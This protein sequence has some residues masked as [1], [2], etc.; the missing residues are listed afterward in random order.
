MNFQKISNGHYV[1]Q[2]KSHYCVSPSCSRQADDGSQ[3]CLIH[4]LQRAEAV[5]CE[6]CQ[7]PFE[8]TQWFPNIACVCK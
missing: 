8:L 1:T 3:Y 2:S 4:R 7:H 5:M 6:D